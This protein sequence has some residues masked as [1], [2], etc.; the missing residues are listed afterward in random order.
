MLEF[1]IHTRMVPT[2]KMFTAKRIGLQQKGSS[3]TQAGKKIISR[4]KDFLRFRYPLKFDL[5]QMNL[6][7]LTQMLDTVIREDQGD[8]ASFRPIVAIGHTKDLV[9]IETVESF[10]CYLRDKGVLVS[11]FRDAHDIIMRRNEGS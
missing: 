9:D 10:L 5:C 7:E 6:K 4:M 1:P 2:W 8:Q 3:A 11:T